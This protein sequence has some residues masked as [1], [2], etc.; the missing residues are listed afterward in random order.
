MN[1]EENLTINN[2]K[3]ETF[4]IPNTIEELLED[5]V[6]KEDSSLVKEHKNDAV[7]IETNKEITD[8]SSDMETDNNDSSDFI[9]SSLPSFSFAKSD[10]SLLSVSISELLSV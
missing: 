4:K 2:E 6:P 10:E 1:E 8:K 5:E 3:E 9:S 7:T